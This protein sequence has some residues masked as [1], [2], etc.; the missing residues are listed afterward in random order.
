MREIYMTLFGTTY[1][2]LCFGLAS[3]ITQCKSTPGPKEY[4]V[5]YQ[6]LND[7]ICEHDKRIGKI[8]L[9]F[10]K[11]YKFD[12]I[13]IYINDKLIEEQVIKTNEKIGYARLVELGN[14]DV[15]DFLQFAI[16]ESQKISIDC[17]INNQI[18]II[19]KEGND[20]IIIKSV[21]VLPRYF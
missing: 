21:C 16:N 2:L 1:I 17:N 6:Y 13:S 12:T 4:Q 7:T 8:A 10:D 5:I 14:L 20:K 19:S 11:L 15:I 18:F 9:C 3:L